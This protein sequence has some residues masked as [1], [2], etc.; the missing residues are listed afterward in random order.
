MLLTSPQEPGIGWESQLRS[1]LALACIALVVVLTACETRSPFRIRPDPVVTAHRL[2]SA[3]NALHRV[4]VV[5]LFPARGSSSA[6]GRS[7]VDS[8]SADLVGSFVAQAL[9]AAGIDVIPPNDVENAFIGTGTPVPR[10][11]GKASAQ[12]MGE[13]FGATG[14]IVGTITRYRD[15]DGSDRAVPRAASVAF[16]VSL[17]QVPTGR[18]LWTGRFDETQVS[19]SEGILRTRRYPGGGMRWLSAAELARWGATEIVA[20]LTST[21]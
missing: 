6:L 7:A 18:R 21:R 5:P 15:R 3:K 4:A 19:I 12:V 13:M 1:P 14:V 11:D 16:E 8:E 10:L 2:G 20:A 9:T 17:H